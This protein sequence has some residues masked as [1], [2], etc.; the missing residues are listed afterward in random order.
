MKIHPVVVT[1]YRWTDRCDEVNYTSPKKNN[2]PKA[3][4]HYI[5]YCKIV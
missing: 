2:D 3:K 1:W 5:K 4:A